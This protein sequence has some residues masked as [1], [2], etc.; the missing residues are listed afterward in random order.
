MADFNAGFSLG[1]WLEPWAK[2]RAF[3]QAHF[4][5]SPNGKIRSGQYQMAMWTSFL[6]ILVT[7][8]YAFSFVGMTPIWTHPTA[9]LVVW[10]IVLGVPLAI[11]ALTFFLA[12]MLVSL[13]HIAS[14][15]ADVMTP[16]ERLEPAYAARRTAYFL[17]AATPRDRKL[18]YVHFWS[19]VVVFFYGAIYLLRWYTE[20]HRLGATDDLSNGYAI[21]QWQHFLFMTTVLCALVVFTS[22]RGLGAYHSV[23]GTSMWSAG[24][25]L[26]RFLTNGATATAG[27]MCSNTYSLNSN[28]GIKVD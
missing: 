21:V 27:R 3:F 14:D 28:V 23:F 17:D 10:V 20:Y 12:D 22:V 18:I 26:S 25:F 7:G 19:L 5:E 11:Y 9:N 1:K 2:A 8:L 4:L 16:G 15:I 6:F 13:Q 24:H